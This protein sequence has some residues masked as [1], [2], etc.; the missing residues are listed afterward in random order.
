MLPF[1][2]LF[3]Q[4]DLQIPD[5]TE[6]LLLLALAVVTVIGHV[7][8]VKALYY[9]DLIVL[10]PVNKIKFVFSAIIDFLLFNEYP[11][12]SL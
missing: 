10:I 4:F 12:F 8:L 2:I 9:A 5:S 6:L 1:N 3:A 7:A 11:K